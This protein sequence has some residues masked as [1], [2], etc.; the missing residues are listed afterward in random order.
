MTALA[1]NNPLRWWTRD[2]T[3]LRKMNEASRLAYQL[4]GLPE[5]A[6][7]EELK[8]IKKRYAEEI[9]ATK[10]QHWIDWLEDIIYGRL[11]NTFLH[12]S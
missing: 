12:T 6:C 1:I 2:L 8:A 3:N 5:H 11:T 4:R 7:H 9:E 10:K